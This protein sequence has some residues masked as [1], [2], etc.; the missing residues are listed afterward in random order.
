MDR[1]DFNKLCQFTFWEQGVQRYVAGVTRIS[2]SE[3]KIGGVVGSKLYVNISKWW[4]D[5]LG[6]NEWKPTR[7]HIFVPADAWL[8]FQKGYA[9]QLLEVVNRELNGAGDAR[10]SSAQN[11][12]VDGTRKGVG[13]CGAS[14]RGASEQA[15]EANPPKLQRKGEKATKPSVGGGGGG[16]ATSGGK[17]SGRKRAVSVEPSEPAATAGDDA[18]DGDASSGSE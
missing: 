12:A 3:G 16:A 18:H 8:E 9:D 2:D 7:K 6:D 1:A 13:K 15:S 11:D 17:K 4:L 10:S 14:K 5:L